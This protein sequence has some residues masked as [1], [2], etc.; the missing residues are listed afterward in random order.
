VL[1]KTKDSITERPLSPG[2]IA[3]Q[4][5][6]AVAGASIEWSLPALTTIVLLDANSHYMYDW[7]NVTM[8]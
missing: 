5:A 3:A 6:H 4:A 1:V 7:H 2:F 8:L